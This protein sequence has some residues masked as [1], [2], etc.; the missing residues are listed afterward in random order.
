M[1]DKKLRAASAAIYLTAALR[2][3]AGISHL[4]GYG[5]DG[6]SIAETIKFITE[7]GITPV[8]LVLFVWFFIS[9]SKDDDNKVKEAYKTAQENMENNNRAVRDREDYLMAESAKREEIIRQEAE[10]R[11]KLIR[12]EAEKRESI[13]MASQDRMLG[14]LDNIATSLNKMEGAL[15][16]LEVSFSKTEARMDVIERK[17]GNGSNKGS[18]S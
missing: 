1:T 16:K 13:L 10:R 5:M 18:G 15:T 12:Q 3:V 2:V 4:G 6:M 7:V 14:T 9:R 8:L 17:L 11:E